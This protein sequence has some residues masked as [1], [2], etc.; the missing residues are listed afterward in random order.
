MCC[1]CMCC[2]MYGPIQRERCFDHAMQGGNQAK[3]IDS[4]RW[5]T[6]EEETERYEEI[7]EKERKMRGRNVLSSSH[8]VTVI[9]NIHHH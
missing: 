2:Y 9:H 5:K 8:V 4:M 6:K 1:S 7:R 3:R